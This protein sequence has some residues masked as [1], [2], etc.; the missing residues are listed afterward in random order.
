M[1]QERQRR[2]VKG[3]LTSVIS[4]TYPSCLLFSSHLLSSS[5]LNAD[6]N[7][8]IF[9][10]ATPVLP[11]DYGISF[12]PLLHSL[13]GNCQLAVRDLFLGNKVEV[14]KLLEM[15]N[16]GCLYQLCITFAAVVGEFTQ[17]PDAGYQRVRGKV[18]PPSPLHRYIF[19]QGGMGGVAPR[20]KRT[21]CAEPLILDAFSQKE[22]HCNTE[23]F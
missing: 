14:V 20:F 16:S 5:I 22:K 3:E 23:A 8:W 15:F 11:K 12:T 19:A 21:H 17:G 9:I 2:K 18:P 6:L 13:N 10:S 4:H 1:I 7:K